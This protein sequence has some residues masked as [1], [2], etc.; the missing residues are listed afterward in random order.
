MES[1]NPTMQWNQIEETL[2]VTLGDL[3]DI[4]A[5]MYF[6]DMGELPEGIRRE[7]LDSEASLA[8]GDVTERELFF[9]GLLPVYQG[10]NYAWSTRRIDVAKLEEV[11]GGFAVGTPTEGAFSELRPSDA[12][13]RGPLPKIGE[14]PVSLMLVRINLQSALR[15]L[16]TLCYLISLLPEVG[17]TMARPD[18]LREGIDEEP[19]R[20]ADFERRLAIIYGY[21][22]E[23][24]NSRHDKTF[25]SE[26][27]GARKRRLF[28]REVLGGG[29]TYHMCGT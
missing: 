23:A 24:W 26:P 9:S 16:T 11:G 10:L 4:Y 25:I 18:G 29:A 20:E 14:A 5:R 13:M 3:R 28:P 22:N 27:D 2:L 12:E 6:A 17:A 15:K 19:F 21:V 7:D 1:Q 8:Q